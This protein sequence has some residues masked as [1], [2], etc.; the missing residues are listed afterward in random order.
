M[1]RF[2]FSSLVKNPGRRM[3]TDKKKNMLLHFASNS[4]PGT[5]VFFQYDGEA[6]FAFSPSSEDFCIYIRQVMTI[7]VVMGPFANSKL[8]GGAEDKEDFFEFHGETEADKDMVKKRVAKLLSGS[9]GQEMN[10]T[11]EELISA[12]LINESFS[13][14][15]ENH[16]K[17]T[18]ADDLGTANVEA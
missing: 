10:A 13:A 8:T 2:R 16:C 17:S 5:G 3:Q 15:E 9:L 1:Y 12:N 14:K 11:K 18:S 7:P 6:R 4:E